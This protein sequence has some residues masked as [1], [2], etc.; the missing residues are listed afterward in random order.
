MRIMMIEDDQKLSR[1]LKLGLTQDGFAVDVYGDGESALREFGA[2][3][4]DLVIVDWR[5]PGMD[6]T[7]VCK[8]IRNKGS[9]V[10]ILFLTA[11]NAVEDKVRGLESGAD[12][13]LTKPFSFI[14]L[15]ARLQ[16]LLRRRHDP[17]E[18]LRIDDLELNVKER[19]AT[20]AGLRIEL[21][22]KEFAILEFFIRN[23]NRLLT[24]AVVV[25]HVWEIDFD[26]GTNLLYVYV[27]QLRRKLDCGSRRPLIHTVRGS[28]YVLREPS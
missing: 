14:E 7:A 9:H 25:N 6:G 5:L 12:D 20:R 11:Q 8:E 2:T 22:N 21:S 28:G 17:I 24:H 18:V 19:R 1:F 10:P 26:T 27:A 4:Y 3:D 13:Y 15:G 16:A 23:K